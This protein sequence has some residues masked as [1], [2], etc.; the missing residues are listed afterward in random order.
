MSVD[1]GFDATWGGT[2]A[3]SY[4]SV[5]DSDTIAELVLSDSDAWTLLPEA[6]K[7]MF[8]MRATRDIDAL[9]FIGQEYY[10]EQLLKWPRYLGRSWS[11]RFIDQTVITDTDRFQKESKFDLQVA[12][13]LQAYA[14]VQADGKSSHASLAA[15]GVKQMSKSVGPLREQYTYGDQGGAFPITDGAI[16]LLRNYTRS[17]GLRRG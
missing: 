4:L 14:A 9:H 11:R 13:L 10:S 8:L 5:L 1:L 15:Q 12:C 2:S 17:R 7:Q 3:T 16:R 6:K